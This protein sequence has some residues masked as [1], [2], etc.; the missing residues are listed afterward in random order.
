MLLNFGSINGAGRLK[1]S[2]NFEI[3]E[4]ICTFVKE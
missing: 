3:L 4:H 1:L 2:I